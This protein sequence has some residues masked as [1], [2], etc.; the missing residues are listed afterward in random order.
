MYGEKATQENDSA[1][2]GCP[3]WI[4]VKMPPG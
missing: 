3:K 2:G 1:M 4:R